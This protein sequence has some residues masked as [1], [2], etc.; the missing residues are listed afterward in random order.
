MNETLIDAIELNNHEEVLYCLRNGADVNKAICCFNDRDGT[1]SFFYPLIH[2]TARNNCDIVQTLLN[3]G[4][5]I[6]IRRENGDTPILVACIENNMEMIG[7]LLNA[8]ADVNDINL[9]GYNTLNTTTQCGCSQQT[10]HIARILLKLGVDVNHASDDGCTALHEVCF[11]ETESE[12]AISLELMRMLLDNGANI[13]AQDE[14]GDTALI[15]CAREGFTDGVKLL[16]EYKAD[17]SLTDKEGKTALDHAKE[18]GFA[19]IENRLFFN[20]DF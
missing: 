8:G 14:H 1:R 18:N 20:V 10:V 15:Q 11:P 3:A 5:N 2:A 6:H 19:D 9:D 7:I 12:K 13:N 17:M 4:A 16:L